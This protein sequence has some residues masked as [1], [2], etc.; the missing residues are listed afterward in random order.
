M[1][2]W[3]ESTRLPPMYE[4]G[5]DSRT[6]RHMWVEFVVGPYSVPRGALSQ[7]IRFSL[8]LKEI[9]ISKF[10]FEY[11]MQDLPENHFAVSGAPCVNIIPFGL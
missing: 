1:V 3:I 6:R 10:Q 8:L 9:Y 2:Q 4:P 5:F 11:R 7:A